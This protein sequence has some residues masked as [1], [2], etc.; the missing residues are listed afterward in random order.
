MTRGV[1]DVIG[2]AGSWRI[3]WML[4]RNDIARRYKRSS[5]GQL[6]LTISMASMIFGMGA[7]YSAIF[8]QDFT[9]YLPFVG[10]GM[11][12]WGL[13]GNCINEGCTSFIDNDSII[14]QTDLPKFTYILRTLV[15]SL[16]VFA[17]NLVIIP[18][19]FLICWTPIGWPILLFIPGLI[20]ALLNLAWIAY[21]LA[22]M[23]ARF[24]DVP[25][26]I[27]SVVQIAFFITPV[28]FRPNQL[29]PDHPIIVLNPFAS[30]LSV[31]RDPLLSQVPSFT[32]YAS[33]LVMLIVGWTVT[34]NFA[35]RYSHRVVYWL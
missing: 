23:S 22:I 33:V 21:F 5:I 10:T 20:L 3:W 14:R 17:H 2:G 27:Q 7:V 6:W 24:R 1:A 19:L 25:Q 15:R 16:I 32:T 29:P 13:I 12:L 18:I 30:L 8:K 4:A 31:F 11:V 35:S 28:V 34:L 9:H 26:I